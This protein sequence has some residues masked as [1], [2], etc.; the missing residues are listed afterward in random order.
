MKDIESSE[1]W[2]RCGLVLLGAAWCDG[3]GWGWVGGGGLREA[4]VRKVLYRLNTEKRLAAKPWPL[5]LLSVVAAGAAPLLQLSHVAAA[6]V[7][8]PP[9][10]APLLL[11]CGNCPM[12]LLPCCCSP[13]LMLLPVAAPVFA[14]PPAPVAS[15]AA[16]IAAP[17][18]AV[19]FV[20][21]AAVAAPATPA[22]APAPA[23]PQLL[24]PL[25]LTT[26]LPMRLSQFLTTS[27]SQANTG[28]PRIFSDRV[29]STAVAPTAHVYYA[30]RRYP[31]STTASEHLTRERWIATNPPPRSCPCSDRQPLKC[32]NLL[33]AQLD[34]LTGW[35]SPLKKREIIEFRV[36]SHN[37][38][39]VPV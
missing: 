32:G 13:L 3:E 31:P 7:V 16:V 26:L 18:A 12:L 28:H 17:A 11:P 24:L 33:K 23:A 35:S 34:W 2:L 1:M 30:S 4:P 29:Y 6:P 25:L 22:A 37:A 14:A 5:N 10:T 20:V 9:V 15:P 27:A 21:V 19:V 39:A 36:T 8:A 38:D